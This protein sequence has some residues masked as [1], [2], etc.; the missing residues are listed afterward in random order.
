VPSDVRR[1]PVRFVPYN[2]PAVVPDWLAE[3]PA[4]PRVCLSLGAANTE[5]YGGDYVSKAA[6]L[7]ALADL[8]VEVVAALLPAQVQELDRVPGNARVVQSVPLHA[9]LPSC[10]ALIH[11]GG[12]GSYATALVHGVPQ[13]FVSTPVADQT[14][15]GSGLQRA[16]AGLYLPHDQ[17]GPQ[18]IRDAVSRL[19][20]DAGFARNAATL[21]DEALQRPAP[22]Q[23]VAELERFTAEQRPAA[24]RA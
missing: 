7:E 24:W 15:R 6:I 12:F 17:G 11:H 18:E 16:G 13:L 19:V 1:V 5:R 21:R 2:G 14:L 3:P 10:A 20:T 22:A 8:D 4:R 9:L 23:V